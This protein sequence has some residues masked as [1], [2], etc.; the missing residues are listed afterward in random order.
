MRYIDNTY[1]H[2]GYPHPGDDTFVELRWLDLKHLTGEHPFEGHRVQGLV[3]W[4]NPDGSHGA[5]VTDDP[6]WLAS[7][8]AEHC[9]EL[10]NVRTFTREVRLTV[11]AWAEAE[12]TPV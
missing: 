5:E 11:S 7:Y 3:T 9:P 10:T 2:A 1:K 12:R 8:Y 4:T 6:G